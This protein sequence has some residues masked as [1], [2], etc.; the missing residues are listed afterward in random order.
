MDQDL[1]KSAI[2][3]YQLTARIFDYEQCINQRKTTEENMSYCRQRLRQGIY[4][5]V[6]CR[7]DYKLN[8]KL[9]KYFRF[10]SAEE[11]IKVFKTL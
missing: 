9:E 4:F 11:D 3:D 2:P 6:S 5:D 1:K 8:E 7:L 10:L